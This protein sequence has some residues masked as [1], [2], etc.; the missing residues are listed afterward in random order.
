M[1]TRRPHLLTQLNIPKPMHGVHPS[2]LLG[3]RWWNNLKIQI[4]DSTQN[5]CVVCGMH[6]DEAFF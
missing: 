2:D 4:L 5:H 1:Y 3:K 6:S